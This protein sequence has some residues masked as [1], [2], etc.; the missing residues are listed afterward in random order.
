MVCVRLCDCV[1]HATAFLSDSGSEYAHS[2]PRSFSEILGSY[3]ISIHTHDH[4][5]LDS[6]TLQKLGHLAVSDSGCW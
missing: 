4:R 1:R 2:Q 5:F 3:F 6:H